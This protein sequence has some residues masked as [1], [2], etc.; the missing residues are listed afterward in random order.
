MEN[1]DDL[2]EL[3]S[4]GFLFSESADRSGP[5]QGKTFCITGGLVSG[6]REEVAA[7]IEKAGGT[8]KSSVSKKIDY[9]IVG[10]GGGAN[11]AEAAKKHGTK[12]ISEEQ[13]Y[14][15]MGTPMPK[16]AASPLAERGEL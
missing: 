16:A 11:K 2:E 7:R 3:E 4:L 10:E 12:V 14:E 8:F 9:L 6:K 1:V 15:M 5:L 13:L